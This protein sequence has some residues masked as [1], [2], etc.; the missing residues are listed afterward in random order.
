[1]MISRSGTQSMAVA[2][3]ASMASASTEGAK[4][5]AAMMTANH[6]KLAAPRRPS[7]SISARSR[8]TEAAGSC[9]Q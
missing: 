3:P 4:A 5:T 1:M 7:G 9:A 8:R 2:R 6:T